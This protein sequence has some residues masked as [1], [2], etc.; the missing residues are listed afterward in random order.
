VRFVVDA[1]LSPV[2]AEGLRTEGHDAVHVVDIGL[3]TASD[4]ATSP[5]PL[6]T[7]A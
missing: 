2:M 1:N 4:E 3:L 6:R 5:Q 7:T